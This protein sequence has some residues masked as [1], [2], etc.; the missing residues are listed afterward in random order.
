MRSMTSVKRSFVLPTLG[1]SSNE[2][3]VG[4]GKVSGQLSLAMLRSSI[5]A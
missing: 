2:N 5:A 3:A 1:Q 4:K